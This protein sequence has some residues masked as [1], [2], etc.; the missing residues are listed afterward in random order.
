MTR[1]ELIGLI[2]V[3]Q[4]AECMNYTTLPHWLPMPERCPFCGMLVDTV[5]AVDRRSET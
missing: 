3:L 2:N 1:D 5:L 4:C